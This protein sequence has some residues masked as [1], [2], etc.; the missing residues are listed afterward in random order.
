MEEFYL[1]NIAM[2]KAIKA[3]KTN[4]KNLIFD[5]APFQMEH[6]VVGTESMS[7][8]VA[9][10]KLMV[11]LTEDYRSFVCDGLVPAMLNI[12]KGFNEDAESVAEILSKN[13]MDMQS[14][15]YDDEGQYGENQGGPADETGMYLFGFHLF[16]D[17]E[18]YEFIRSHKGYENLTDEEIDKLLNVLNKTGCSYAAACNAIFEM[19]QYN[20]QGFEQ[21]FGFPMYDD[22]GDFNYNYLLVD[23]F[24]ETRNKYYMGENDI[25]GSDALKYA[26]CAHYSKD[27][28]KTFKE[29]YGIELYSDSSCQHYSQEALKIIRREVNKKCNGAEV[30]TFSEDSNTTLC[31]ENRL[32]HYLNSHGVDGFKIEEKIQCDTTKSEMT[33][34]EIKSELEAGNTVIFSASNFNLYTVEEEQYNRE[35]VGGHYMTVTGVT[36]DGYLIVSSWGKKLLY[37]PDG[38]KYADCPDEYVIVRQELE[39]IQGDFDHVPV[40]VA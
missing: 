25:N 9:D 28:G 3:F 24:L 6:S 4:G 34:E 12:Q 10:S 26:M 5:K 39:V 30:V 7:K 31:I 33:L 2:T 32:N 37:K 15:L 40:T 29:E 14:A 38:G 27:D 8:L 16:H 35:R 36:D 11:K 22:N 23:Y 21:A 1:D 13:G 17:K 19:F 18:L 20:P